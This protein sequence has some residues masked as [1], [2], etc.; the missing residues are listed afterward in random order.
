MTSI[1]KRKHS[2]A[3]YYHNLTPQSLEKEAADNEEAEN[4]FIHFNYKYLRYKTKTKRE[5]EVL[6][7]YL[8]KHEKRKTNKAN[9]FFKAGQK[10]D[11]KY[12]RDF[13]TGLFGKPVEEIDR[14]Y[15]LKNVSL[16]KKTNS[17]IIHFTN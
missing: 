17:A 3:V 15:K 8:A 1:F 13:P 5:K 9:E 4:C 10:L 14:F 12:K 6:A 11:F 16:R 7:D 2:E